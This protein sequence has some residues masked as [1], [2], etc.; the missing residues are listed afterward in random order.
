MV[1][2]PPV[3]TCRGHGRLLPKRCTRASGR[4]E[5]PLKNNNKTFILGTTCIYIYI[6]ISPS[7]IITTSQQ[8]VVNSTKHAARSMFFPPS[9]IQYLASQAMRPDFSAQ[10]LATL[11]W[12]MSSATATFAW[13]PL[14]VRL[15]QQLEKLPNS[16]LL[17]TTKA[18]LR[19]QD[20]AMGTHGGK[21][22]QHENDVKIHQ[23][24]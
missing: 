17:R 19:L 11:L 16:L 23:L 6:I 7:E 10:H 1:C 21:N 8:H 14:A 24:D 20:E 9:G 2:L 18:Q 5:S 15:V 12:L 4:A 22:K 13:R 3:L